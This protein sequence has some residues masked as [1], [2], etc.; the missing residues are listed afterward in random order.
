MLELAIQYGNVDA[1]NYLSNH[2][3]VTDQHRCIAMQ[4]AKPALIKILE[5]PAKTDMCIY[6]ADDKD[7]TET[8]HMCPKYDIKL[9]IMRMFQLGDT[10]GRILP[11]I[12]EAS[13]TDSEHMELIGAAIVYRRAT[14]VEQLCTRNQSIEEW[15]LLIIFRYC[16][17]P[18][19]ATRR[20]GIR[21]ATFFG[22]EKFVAML[23]DDVY[24]DDLIRAVLADTSIEIPM[25][26]RDMIIKNS[27]VDER[28][29]RELSER[30]DIANR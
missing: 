1:V 25:T 12:H 14:I 2:C 30:Y 24:S 16:I 22:L 3:I 27:G 11:R 17:D 18:R 26:N 6:S 10:D 8:V 13:L 19:D 7:L 23:G 28:L 21:L 29:K 5:M 15:D 4:F 20:D 9:T